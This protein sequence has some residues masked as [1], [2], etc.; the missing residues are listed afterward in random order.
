M[1]TKCSPKALRP[2]SSFRGGRGD[3]FVILELWGGGEM[4]SALGSSLDCLWWGWHPL[5][6]E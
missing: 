6:P 2:V 4:L 5:A 1:K 3:P